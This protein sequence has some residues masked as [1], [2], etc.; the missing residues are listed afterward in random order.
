[1]AAAAPIIAPEDQKQVALLQVRVAPS[2]ERA[3]A[4]VV[5]TQEDYERAGDF[6]RDS[7]T[8]QKEIHDAL[9]PVVQKA[10]QA[11]KAAT[12]VQS[13]LLEPL[14]EAEKIVKGKMGAYQ[15]ERERIAL[16]EQREKEREARRLEEERILREAQELE[17]RGDVQAAEEVISAPIVTTAIPAA[18]RPTASGTAAR[19]KYS[20]RVTDLAA[21]VKASAEGKVPAGLVVADVSALN[22]LASA[23]KESLSIP[24]VELVREPV[25]AAQARR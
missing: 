24:G 18:P 2:G 8:L 17:A 20:A 19:W 14:V 25:I 6:L 13:R 4:L 9:D 11:H 10:H 12:A 21:L 16:A 15:E 3:R 5:K 22:K 7:K 23:L 1:M